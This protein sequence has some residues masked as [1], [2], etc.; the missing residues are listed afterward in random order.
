MGKAIGRGD[1]E[2]GQREKM[3]LVLIALEYCRT[4]S[5]QRKWKRRTFRAAAEGTRIFSGLSPL[6]LTESTKQQHCT[7]TKKWVRG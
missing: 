3:G 5:A 4:C 6:S 2:I 1:K 7:K